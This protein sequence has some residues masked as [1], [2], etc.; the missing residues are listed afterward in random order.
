MGILI[1]GLFAF[2]FGGML[3]MLIFGAQEI[4]ARRH[5]EV[6]AEKLRAEAA[7]IPRFFVVNQQPRNGVVDEAFAAHVRAYLEIE[8]MLADEF[9][10]HPSLESLYRNSGSRLQS[11]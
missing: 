3:L 6:E 9:V 8:Q 10:L 2:L 11:H 4:E 1:G 5:E 7:R